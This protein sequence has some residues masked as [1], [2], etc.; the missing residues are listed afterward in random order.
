MSNI[1]QRTRFGLFAAADHSFRAR[2]FHTVSLLYI[3]FTKH[4]VVTILLCSRRS[5]SI[6]F[7]LHHFE[8]CRTQHIHHFEHMPPLFVQMLQFLFER[9]I[10][11]IGR[12]ER[13]RMYNTINVILLLSIFCLLFAAKLNITQSLFHFKYLQLQ[14]IKLVFERIKVSHFR[15][16]LFAQNA[17]ISIQCVSMMHCCVCNCSMRC[18]RLLWWWLLSTHILD[19]IIEIVV[20]V[21]L[22]SIV[23]FKHGTLIVIIVILVLLTS[24][25]TTTIQA[26]CNFHP[27]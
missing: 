9:T 21:K 23:D 14:I 18:L 8:I 17:S 19:A 27:Q 1:C 22:K 11:L 15:L 3:Y 16:F 6:R 13:R 2:F 25:H 20:I 10:F 7:F 26:L 5:Y 24:Y 4:V 12:F